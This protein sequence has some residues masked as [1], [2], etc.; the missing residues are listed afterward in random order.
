MIEILFH[1]IASFIHYQ[2]M[3]SRYEQDITTVE[4]YCMFIGYPR[5]G[6]S[7]VGSLLDA[8]PDMIIAHELDALQHIEKGISRKMLFSL[9]IEKSRKFT[10]NRRIWSGYSYEIPNQWNGKYRQLKVIG[11]KKTG[12]STRRLARNP[13]LLDVLFKTLKM[14]IAFIHL[15]RNPYD[16]ISTMATR[17]DENLAISITKYFRLCRIISAIK[18][19]IDDD[20]WINVRHEDIIER[21]RESLIRLC[22]FLGLNYTEDYL[23]DCAS[24]IYKSPHKSRLKA[25]WNHDLIRLVQQEIEKY[26]LL[27]GYSFDD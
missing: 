9:L 13:K 25:P 15:T 1:K 17:N 11:D 10:A 24:I 4:R 20:H 14:H 2:I 21:P 16:N 5:S 19:K 18:E 6:S 22:T 23:R 7:L 8:H 27:R 12:S 3:Y 26:P